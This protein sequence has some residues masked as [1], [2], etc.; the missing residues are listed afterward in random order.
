MSAALA[1]HELEREDLGDVTV[2]RFTANRL[3]E[4]EHIRLLFQQVAGL[5]DTGHPNLV[6]NFRSVGFL[7]STA[8]GKLMMLHGKARTARGRVAL[9]HV[10][11]ATDEALEVLHLKDIIQT[12]DSE[13]E[14]LQSF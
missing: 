6:L 10:S 14:A 12:Y 7:A 2:V 1:R 13:Q 5:V 11:R 9:C 8:I 3:D 4:E